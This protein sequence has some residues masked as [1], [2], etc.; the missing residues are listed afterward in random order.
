MPVNLEGLSAKELDAL[1]SKAKQRKQKLQKRPPLAEVRKALAALAKKHGY[2]L[3]EVL[4]GKAAVGG[5]KPGRKAGAKPRK[6]PAKG[7]KVPPKYRHPETGETWSGR[8]IMPKWL[9]A[10]VAKGRTR[11]EFAI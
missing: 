3:A 5:R 2:T 6:S 1:I 11:E 10:E 7:S 8:G 4:G 9:A